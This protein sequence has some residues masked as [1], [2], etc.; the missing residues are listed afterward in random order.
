M[1]RLEWNATGK[2]FFE[3]GVD[4]GVLYAEGFGG[5][6]WN[7]LTQV[8]EKPSGGAPKPYYIDG[9]KYLNLAAPEEFEGSIQAFTYPDEWAYCDGTS[10]HGGALWIAQQRRVP[11]G[12]SYRTGIGNDLEGLDH[13]YKLHVIYNALSKPASKDYG[14]V[15]ENVDPGTFTWEFTT[16]PEDMGANYRPSAHMI[17]DSRKIPASILKPIEDI[18]YG[19]ATKSPRLIKPTELFALV[20]SIVVVD[21]GN[22]T[23]TV[24]GSDTE[25]QMLE[26]N[27]FRITSP[28]AEYLDDDTYTIKG[29][30]D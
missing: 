22:G 10:N 21:N 18:L 1:T 23:F 15:G 28:Y 3:A 12:L 9:K 17:I 24:T 4:R 26:D 13:A 19:T 6:P 20:P 2:R 5:V 27:Q 30:G 29:A 11:F 16:T 8:T 14:T 25:I 7:G